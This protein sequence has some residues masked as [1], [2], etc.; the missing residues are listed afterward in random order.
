[1]PENPP[2][3]PQGPTKPALAPIDTGIPT[4]GAPGGGDVVLPG[5]AATI[6][7]NSKKTV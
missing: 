7:G 3:A 1:M 5:R 6:A 4:G 2:A